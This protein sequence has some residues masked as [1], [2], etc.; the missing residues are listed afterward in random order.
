[1]SSLGFLEVISEQRLKE[2]EKIRV[3]KMTIKSPEIALK[4]L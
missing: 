4:K 1:M 3:V 2:D